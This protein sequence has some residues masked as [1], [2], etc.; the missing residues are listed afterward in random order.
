MYYYGA[1]GLRVLLYQQV[2][3]GKVA[4]MEGFRRRFLPSLKTGF[5]VL[6]VL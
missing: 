5:S 2:A 4:Q 6:G 3:I 1:Q